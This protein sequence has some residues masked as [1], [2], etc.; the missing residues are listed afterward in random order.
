[1]VRVLADAESEPPSPRH[2]DE[3]RALDTQFIENRHG[4]RDPKRHCICVGVVRFV[5]ASEAAVVDE[6]QAELIAERLDQIYVADGC[7]RIKKSTMKDDWCSGPAIILEV[8]RASIERVLG[9]GH[10]PNLLGPEIMRMPD[11]WRPEANRPLLMACDCYDV[12]E[13]SLEAGASN[14]AWSAHSASQWKNMLSPKIRTQSGIGSR[15]VRIPL[16]EA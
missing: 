12:Q 6:D 11:P 4:V 10:D 3:V 14:K 16:A 13:P 9:V 5:A 1:L 2:T 7:D 15:S 8:R